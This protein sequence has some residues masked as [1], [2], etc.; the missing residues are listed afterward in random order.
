MVTALK[1]LV[2]MMDLSLL[3]SRS[4]MLFVRNFE[5]TIWGADFNSDGA[6]A[7]LGT[8]KGATLLN[9][10]TRSS[11][12]IYRSKSDVLSQQYACS[13]NVVLCGLRN[14][15]IHVIDTRENSQNR[16]DRRRNSTRRNENNNK[17]QN[18]SNSVRMSSAV[19]SLVS[20]KSDENYF[21]GSS[22]DGS[23]KLFDMRALKNG[24]V[25]S[26][27]GHVN[28][29]TRLQL[30]VNPS[31]TLFLSGGQDCGV[32]IWSIKSG[33]LLFSE[34]F[35]DSVFTT[36]CWPD[37]EGLPN[38]E[39]RFNLGKSCGAWLGSRSSLSYVNFH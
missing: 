7:V 2:C 26:Y 4:E 32:R 25:Q 39:D 20:L 34:K 5:C 14:G 37:L 38:L 13:G 18:S 27:E 35:S 8:S 33:E 23:I 36:A 21:L 19:C 29:H 10:E 11:T 31:E 28:S 16:S 15:L 30:A 9:V 6:H 24:G 1:G 3:G 22:M 12:W 17:G